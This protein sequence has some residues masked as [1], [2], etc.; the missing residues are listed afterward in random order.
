MG[1]VEQIASPLI[2]N[3]S[4]LSVEFDD[5]AVFD[6]PEISLLK[7]VGGDIEGF[8]IPNTLCPMEHDNILV[9]I[10]SYRGYRAESL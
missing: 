5:C 7:D 4:S 8:G 2:Q 6:W 1:H 10:K 3:I 9:Y